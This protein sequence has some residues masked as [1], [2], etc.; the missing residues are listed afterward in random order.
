[1]KK[2]ISVIVTVTVVALLVGVLFGY[3]YISNLQNQIGELQAENSELTDQI[4]QLQDQKNELEEENSEL[5]EQNDKLERQNTELQNMLLKEVN[6]VGL[7]AGNVKITS[8]SIHHPGLIVFGH[9][10]WTFDVTI[11]NTGLVD[12]MG[13]TLNV[14]M[15]SGDYSYYWTSTLQL[16]NIGSGDECTISME[17]ASDINGYM[18]Y[19]TP[20]SYVA[21]LKLDNIVL[22]EYVY[23]KD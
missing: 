19:F 4:T 8:L 6:Y 1:M 23:V 17:A 15:P 21:V 10:R 14:K 7:L 5:Q 3:I 11:Q 18:A 16:E 20:S 12:L 9:A 2:R 22:D 13:A